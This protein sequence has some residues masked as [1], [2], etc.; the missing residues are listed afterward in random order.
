[1]IFFATSSTTKNKKNRSPIEIAVTTANDPSKVSYLFKLLLDHEADV[2][3]ALE[4]IIDVNNISLLKL[5]VEHC[6]KPEEISSLVR[7][8][9]TSFSTV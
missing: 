7:D 6:P 5:I 3:L 2:N 9:N 4:A 8:N 1:M